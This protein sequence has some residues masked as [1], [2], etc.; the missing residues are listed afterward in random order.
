MLANA[1]L[2]ETIG[3]NIAGGG[4]VYTCLM[5]LSKAFERVDHDILIDMLS[6]KSVPMSIVNIFRSIYIGSSVQVPIF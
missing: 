3:A 5:D 6:N 4:S 2:K 1:L